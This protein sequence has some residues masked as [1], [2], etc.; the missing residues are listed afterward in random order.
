MRDLAKSH[1]L[2]L[3]YLAR[4]PRE[5]EDL[6]GPELPANTIIRDATKTLLDAHRPVHVVEDGRSLGVVDSEDVLALISGVA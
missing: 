1:V 2:T 3:R 6:S 4:P 5:G